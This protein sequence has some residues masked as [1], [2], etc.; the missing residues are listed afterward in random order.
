LTAIEVLSIG[1]VTQYALSEGES[2]FPRSYWI[3]G[4]L[5]LWL[6][7]FFVND[8][9]SSTF[10]SRKLTALNI[11]QRQ[12]RALVVFLSSPNQ[13]AFPCVS[14]QS[15]RENKAEIT[16]SQ[17]EQ[18]AQS[19]KIDVGETNSPRGLI[20]AFFKGE[21]KK[22]NGWPLVAALRA[23]AKRLDHLVL[24]GSKQSASAVLPM[25]EYL[26]K[27]LPDAFNM[28][29]LDAE[30]NPAGVPPSWKFN[31]I[32]KSSSVPVSTTR[33]Q[34]KP[35]GLDIGSQSET[36]S[37][38]QACMNHLSNLGIADRDICFETTSAPRLPNLIAMVETINRDCLISTVN[39]NR[40]SEQGAEPCEL[41]DL[42]II[43]ESGKA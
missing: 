38:V 25:G 39:T 5:L 32:E 18:V 4:F 36:E 2:S 42:Q 28:I 17:E 41:W 34:R 16:G 3:L 21:D 33:E 24:I 30:T 35:Y 1:A 8:F 26:L 19:E 7:W 15:E 11:Q 6:F 40:L 9:L 12:P 27:H 43:V 22:W 14:A 31:K 23:Y 13:I 37:A 20:Q 10:T 29:N